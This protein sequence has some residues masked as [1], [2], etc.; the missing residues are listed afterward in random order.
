ML[1]HEFE[2]QLTD[3]LDGT[4]SAETNRLFAEH[5]IRCPICHDLL[6][7]VKNT[8]LVCSSSE[9]PPAGAGLDARILLRT[10]P[11]TAITCADWSAQTSDL[12]PAIPD[13]AAVI[14]RSAAIR[15][16]DWVMGFV[17]S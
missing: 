17:G 11:E 16:M 6:S 9:A 3:Y 7:E 1:C 4:L 14:T 13:A 10:A 2:K 8:L 5:A 15:L 12:Q